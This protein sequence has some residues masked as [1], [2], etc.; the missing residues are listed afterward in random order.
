MT[1]RNDQN[2]RLPVTKQTPQK[3]VAR[4]K[5]SHSELFI[6]EEVNEGTLKTLLTE[7]ISHETR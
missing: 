1:L 5:T 7:L 3:L 6:Y 4:L 2:D